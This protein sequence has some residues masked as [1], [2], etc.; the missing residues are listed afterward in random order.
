[1]IEINFSAKEQPGFVSAPYQLVDFSSPLT[2]DD[3]DN[4]RY[5]T[6]WGELILRIGETYVS[7]SPDEL[8]ELAESARQTGENL[9]Q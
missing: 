8:A 3:L 7:Y 5:D 1:M 4:L 6:L 2:E 9:S